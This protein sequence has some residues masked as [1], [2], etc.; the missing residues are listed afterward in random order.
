MSNDAKS[1]THR[2]GTS[3]AIAQ[4]AYLRIRSA[5][6]RLV[7]Q[8]THLID[9]LSAC[10]DVFIEQDGQTIYRDGLDEV[11][12]GGIQKLRAQLHLKFLIESLQSTKLLTV[13][14]MSILNEL[15]N[16]PVPYPG[17]NEPPKGEL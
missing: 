1:L 4:E 8:M 2:V 7:E 17:T 9:C 12:S 13:L 10:Y 3:S 14:E 6:P 15:L 11:V 5:S 16:L